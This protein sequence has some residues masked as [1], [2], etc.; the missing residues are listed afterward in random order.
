MG[1]RETAVSRWQQAVDLDATHGVAHAYL[2]QNYWRAGE[3]DAATEALAQALKFE[4]Q[5][6]LALALQQQLLA[7]P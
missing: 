3:R 4:P 7:R 1:E 2:A 6:K 5:N